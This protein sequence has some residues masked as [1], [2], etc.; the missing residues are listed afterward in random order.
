MASSSLFV[1]ASSPIPGSTSTTLTKRR[2]DGSAANSTLRVWFD[3]SSF[4]MA[5][6]TVPITRPGGKS[7]RSLDVVVTGSPTSIVARLLMPC[8][9]SIVVAELVPRA[10]PTSPETSTPMTKSRLEMSLTMD[11]ERSTCSTRP[12]TPAAVITAMSR[13]TP[14]WLPTSISTTPELKFPTSPVRTRARTSGKSVRSS[15]PLMASS[16]SKSARS[17]PERTISPRSSSFS[18]RNASFSA[19]SSSNW[20]AFSQRPVTGETMRSPPARKGDTTSRAPVWIVP[21]GPN[22]WKSSVISVAAARRMNPSVARRRPD[23]WGATIR[24]LR[25]CPS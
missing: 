8:A 5:L 6:L 24:G 15:R 3:A 1:R 7:V 13:C 10:R 9:I 2:S 17:T 18:A 14:A 21:R 22:D 19:W 20:L 11:E 23:C 25:W 12:T 4:W 16:A